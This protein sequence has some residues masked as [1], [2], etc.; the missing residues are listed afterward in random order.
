MKHR[1]TTAL[2]PALAAALA[3]VAVTAAMGCARALP[4]VPERVLFR[5]AGVR[6]LAPAELGVTMQ[7]D[8]VAAVPS[9]QE[10]ELPGEPPIARPSAAQPA[11]DE[12]DPA[13]ARPGRVHARSGR[14]VVRLDDT[15]DGVAPAHLRVTLL[16]YDADM[17]ALS[18]GSSEGRRAARLYFIPTSEGGSPEAFAAAYPAAAHA[19]R[20][21]RAL[22]QAPFREIPELLPVLPATGFHEVFRARCHRLRFQNGS[23]FAC[24]AQYGEAPV[25]LNNADLVYVF[26]GLTDDGSVYVSAT[27]PVRAPGLPDARQWPPPPREPPADGEAVVD[28]FDSY[29][30]GETERLETLGPAEFQPDLERL[31]SLFRSIA[32]GDEETVV[33]PPQPA[34]GGSDVMSD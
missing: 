11:P 29:L 21:L 23:G 28:D 24:L 10:L 26:Q 5:Y 15:A 31:D 6:F 18:G 1:T 32:L 16:D 20:A 4:P 33:V 19:A 8:I 12:S 34:G 25:A 3:V 14:Q 7:A 2:R 22:L 17:L 9:V 13:P 30:K 27:F